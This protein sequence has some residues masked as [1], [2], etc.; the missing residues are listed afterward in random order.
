MVVDP[1]HEFTDVLCQLGGPAA[2]YNPGSSYPPVNN[3]GFVASYAQTCS[4]AQQTRDVAEI[5]KCY[6]PD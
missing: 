4:K 1:G 2:K 5:L 3:S 6:S